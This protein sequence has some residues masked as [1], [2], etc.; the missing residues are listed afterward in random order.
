MCVRVSAYMCVCFC[1]CGLC[2]CRLC[3]CGLCVCEYVYV[4]MQRNYVWYVLA[5]LYLLKENSMK[6]K[7]AYTLQYVWN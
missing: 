1:V 5:D 7:I 6:I 2:V 3:V 4:C